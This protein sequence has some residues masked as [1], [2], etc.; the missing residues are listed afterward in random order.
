M[1]YT[2]N[3][4]AVT[5][6]RYRPLILLLLLLLFRVTAVP[7]S[8]IRPSLPSKRNILCGYNLLPSIRLSVSLCPSITDKSIRRIFNKYD[9][10]PQ[11]AVQQSRPHFPPAPSDLPAVQQHNVAQCLTAPHTCTISPTTI[12]LILNGD[13]ILKCYPPATV[14]ITVRQGRM[15]QGSSFRAI[16]AIRR[17]VAASRAATGCREV[18]ATAA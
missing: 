9:R 7:L 12:V 15:K 16:I 11:N 6:L 2:H 13:I 8:V 3:V 14:T 10:S 1:R 18:N 17:S 5:S 4:S